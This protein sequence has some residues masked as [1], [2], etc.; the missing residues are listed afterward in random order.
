MKSRIP[1]LVAGVLASSVF[2]LPASAQE[3]ACPVK[4]G[5]VLSLTGPIGSVGQNIAKSAQLAITTINE[6]GGVKGC[7]VE[8]VLRDDG[9]VFASV[10]LFLIFDLAEVG[11]IQ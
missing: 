6:G 5:G 2:V 4:I 8:L 10:D 9:S 1:L 3:V 7:P 11:D